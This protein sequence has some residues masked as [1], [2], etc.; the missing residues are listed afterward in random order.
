M[1]RLCAL[2]LL[3]AVL[4]APAPGAQAQAQAQ[5]QTTAPQTTAHPAEQLVAGL[6]QNMISITARFTGSDIL[7]FGAVKRTA[8]P[9]SFPPMQVIVT[10]EGPP[11]DITVR[12]KSRVAGIW[13]NTQSEPLGGVPTFY[14]VAASTALSQA[15]S[16]EEDARFGV[17]VGR[18]IAYADEGNRDQPAFSRALIRLRDQNGAFATAEDAV[19]LAEETLFR[20]S[21]RMPANLTEGSYTTRIFLTRGGQVIDMKESRIDVQ[22][23][24]LERFLFALSREAPLIYGLMSL[25]LAAAAGW[26]ASALF[27]FIRR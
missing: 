20:A 14:A 1:N 2:G 9:P 25:A 23:V 13:V 19:E 27:G 26:A 22:K 24:G 8:P 11:E 21:F 7:V 4:A 15:L 18:K 16:A 12:R 10:L 17:S 6:S 3:A 5:A